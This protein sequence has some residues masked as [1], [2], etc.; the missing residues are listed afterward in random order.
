MAEQKIE[1]LHRLL[2]EMTNHYEVE[3]LPWKNLKPS[4][5][6]YQLLVNEMPLRY[7]K[8]ITPYSRICLL[9]QM[10]SLMDTLLCPRF[11]LQALHYQNALFELID[12]NQDCNTGPKPHLVQEFPLGMRGEVQKLKASIQREEPRLQDFINPDIPMDI[13][14]KRYKHTTRFDPTE[15]TFEWEL[16]LYE[17]EKE[18]EEFMKSLHKSIE[19]KALY[20]DIKAK[21]WER[22]GIVWKNPSLMNPMLQQD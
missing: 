12:E 16:H 5:E 21:A 15:R 3:H 22:R 2:A 9:A 13:W 8:D 18:C 11:I 1:Q 17:V 6:F 20:W 14:C 19:D 4:H 10:T 7:G